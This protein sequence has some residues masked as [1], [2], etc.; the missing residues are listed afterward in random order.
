VDEC[1]DL[2]QDSEEK[3]YQQV[4]QI[5]RGGM[6]QERGHGDASMLRIKLRM[7]SGVCGA[8]TPNSCSLATVLE[9]G[10]RERR[11]RSAK[12]L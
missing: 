8:P 3:R 5:K 7:P 1:A 2:L 9:Q 11:K 6:V 10:K 12:D 4:R